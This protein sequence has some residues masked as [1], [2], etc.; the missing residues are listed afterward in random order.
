MSEFEQILEAACN[1]IKTASH[2][3]TFHIVFEYLRSHFPE[4]SEDDI[5]SLKGFLPLFFGPTLGLRSYLQKTAGGGFSTDLI[6]LILAFRGGDDLKIFCGKNRTVGTQLKKIFDQSRNLNVQTF[7]ARRIH[8]SVNIDNAYINVLESRF[9]SFCVYMNDKLI[10]VNSHQSKLSKDVVSEVWRTVAQFETPSTQLQ[11]LSQWSS[12]TENISSDLILP[13]PLNIRFG[14]NRQELIKDVEDLCASRGVEAKVRMLSGSNRKIWVDLDYSMLTEE[15]T[16]TPILEFKFGGE[17][18]LKK[19]VAKWL[20]SHS[21]SFKLKKPW[22]YTRS[23]HEIIPLVDEAISSIKVKM[24][25][26]ILDS[27]DDVKMSCPF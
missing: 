24:A 8:D 26:L 1:F 27:F 14:D 21:P 17:V 13:L 15:A 12:Y 2:P 3:P 10:Y 18:K 6:L 9:F 20:K 19:N 7:T 23:A 22:T 5:N 4:I 11:R 16:P 25:N